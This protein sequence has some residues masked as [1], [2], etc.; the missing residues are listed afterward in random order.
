M[1]LVPGDAAS[2]DI[3]STTGALGSRTSGGLFMREYRK[4][5]SSPCLW[6]AIFRR[7]SLSS[8]RDSQQTAN[9]RVQ[10]TRNSSRLTLVVRRNSM[11]NPW[12][13]IPACDYEA[14][15]ALPEVAQTQAISK[16]M[17]SALKEYAPASLAVMGCTTGNGFDHI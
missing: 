3:R 7:A 12:L 9:Q 13:Q 2:W 8:T 14:H 1:T 16:L 10:A 17:A 5:S 15:M 11:K 4:R 6:M